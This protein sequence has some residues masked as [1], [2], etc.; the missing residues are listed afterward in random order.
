MTPDTHPAPR[1]ARHL[2]YLLGALATLGPFSIDTYMPAFPAMGAALVASPLQIQQTLTVYLLA[3]AAM[4][5][6]H[7]ALS[8]A[9]GR[10]PI[11]LFSLLLYT[12]ASIGCAFT[13]NIHVLFALRG[14]VG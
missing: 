5:L 12:V 1:H 13:D 2:P 14:V 8:D 11:V 4:M 10:R 7:G 3:F 6:F 9:Y